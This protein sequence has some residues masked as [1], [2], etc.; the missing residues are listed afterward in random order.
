MPTKLMMSFLIAFGQKTKA[1][2]TM[3]LTYWFLR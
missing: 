3:G 1:P 2:V